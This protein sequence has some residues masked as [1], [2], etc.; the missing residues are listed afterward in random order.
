MDRENRPEAGGRAKFDHVTAAPKGWRVTPVALSCF[1]AVDRPD[2][3]DHAQTTPDA[4]GT[5]ADAGRI[6][7]RLTART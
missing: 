2:G 1:A 6:P 5:I 3:A 7:S 4:V